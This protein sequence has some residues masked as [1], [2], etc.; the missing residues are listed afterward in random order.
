MHEEIEELKEEATSNN[1]NLEIIRK[2]FTNHA[3]LSY[4]GNSASK[5]PAPP[6]AYTLIAAPSEDFPL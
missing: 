5:Q 4:V 6:M 1:I 2:P 3:R